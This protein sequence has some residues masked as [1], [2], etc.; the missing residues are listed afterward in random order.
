MLGPRLKLEIAALR[1]T[2]GRLITAIVIHV[3]CEMPLCTA[4]LIAKD[5]YLVQVIL[6]VHIKSIIG[7]YP[8]AT[9]LVIDKHRST[10]TGADVL[11]LRSF[12][13]HML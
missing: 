7:L 12:L 13:S 8:G 9:F 2:N 5:Y 10:N 6:S 3:I 4:F 11:M 1:S